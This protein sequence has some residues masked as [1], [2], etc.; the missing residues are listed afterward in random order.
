MEEIQSVPTATFV[1]RECQSFITVVPI[2]KP[3][4][5]RA[6]LFLPVFQSRSSDKAG[7]C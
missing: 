7:L 4:F 2:R 1:F 3:V 6:S 5:K